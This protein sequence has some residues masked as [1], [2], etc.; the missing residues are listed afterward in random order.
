[1]SSE[2]FL[3]YL[4]ATRGSETEATRQ[5]RERMEKI[6]ATIDMNMRFNVNVARRAMVL[7]EIFGSPVS[8]R[9]GRRRTL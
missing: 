9:H 2:A 5:M 6:G 1:M 4:V 3:R 8:K 7:S